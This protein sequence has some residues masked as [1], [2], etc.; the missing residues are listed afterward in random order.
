MLKMGVQVSEALELLFQPYRE[1]LQK[2][3]ALN[4]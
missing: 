3:P 2:G 4:V 1:K